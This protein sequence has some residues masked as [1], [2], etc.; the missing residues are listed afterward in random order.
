[1]KPI[2]I[3]THEEIR[4]AINNGED[5]EIALIDQLVQTILLLA[6][7]IQV[8]EDQ[9]ARNSNNSS[10]PP[11]SD[12]LKKPAPKSQRKRHDKKTGG[13]PG[14]E[15]HTLKAVAHPQYLRV[16][17]VEYCHQCQA[18]LEKV[19]ASKVEKRQVFDLPPLQ[20]EVTEHRAEI[21]GCPHC[22]A[23][24]QASFPAGVTQPV[25]YGKGI[26]SLA[27]YLNHYQ[28]LPLERVSE[29]FADVF[30]HKLAEGSILAAGEEVAKQV[31]SVM[32]AIKKHLTKDE[33]VVH[34]DETGT[35]IN[36]KLHWFHS[37]S[38]ERLTYYHAHAKRGK[39]AS[40]EIGILPD[41]KGRAVHD[42]WKS[43]FRYTSIRH[44][45]CNVHHLREL[46]FLE[47]RYPQGWETQMKDLL[48]EIRQSIKQVQDQQANLSAGQLSAFEQRYDTLIEQGLQA[49]PLS[50][51]PEDQPKK[52]GKVAKSP[53]RNLLERLQEHKKA[54]LAFMYDFKVPF[55]NNQAERDIRMMKV[56]MKVSGGFRSMKGAETFCSV[57]SYLSNARKNGQRMLEV[58]RM[59]I[60]GKPYCPSFVAFQA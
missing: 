20:V 23:K 2:K 40:D 42:G 11:S 60:N 41:F 8:L 50:P 31:Q 5:A 9:L 25:Q 45:L 28:M 18:N 21:K 49:N 44:A 32:K 52:R 17:T 7:R 4:E 59:A 15:G 12:G 53:S 6:E 30:G 54:V 38:T 36:G 58:L 46:S 13:Q 1:M 55:D 51:P 16:H 22:G 10:K 26:K 47:E 29:T 14:H 19:K 33:A 34:F 48:L 43:Y 35:H 56:K 39:E 24:T 27:V 37:A 57:R 3:P